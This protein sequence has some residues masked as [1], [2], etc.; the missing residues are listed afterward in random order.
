M[1]EPLSIVRVPVDSLMTHPNNVRKGNT[2]A[3]K[4]SLTVNGQYRPIVAQKETRHIIAGNH[5]YLAARELGWTEIHVVWVDVDD[6][7][8]IRIML[9]DN[10]TSDFGSYDDEGL[11]ELLSM[12]ET[13]DGTGFDLD[14]V[15]DLQQLTQI[16]DVQAG[17]KGSGYSGAALSTDG[18]VPDKGFE[19][20]AE[21]YASK[22]VRSIILAYNLDEFE[23]AARLLASARELT[24]TESNSDAVLAVL[25]D[26]V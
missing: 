5:T 14:D 10:R 23:E 13:L 6:E 2:K 1:I 22:A 24:G 3:I 7:A 18:I 25:R 21:G 9:A 11:A 17:E 16:R 15:S 20:W 19:G 4:E 8:A 26:L 12:L